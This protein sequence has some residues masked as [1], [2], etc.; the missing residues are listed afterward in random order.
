MNKNGRYI[1]IM[2]IKINKDVSFAFSVSLTVIKFPLSTD[3]QAFKSDL[4]L[5]N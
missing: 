4:E 3:I 1:Y 5:H 2:K